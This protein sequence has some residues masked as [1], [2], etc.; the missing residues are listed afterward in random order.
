MT[1]DP[2]IRR[3]VSRLEN[4]TESIYELIDDFRTE[5][6]TRFVQVEATLASHDTRFDRVEA[7]LSEIVRRLPEPSWATSFR[8]LSGLQFTRADEWF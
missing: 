7:T 5:T 3:R 1:S 8:Q 2:N 6:R 4:E